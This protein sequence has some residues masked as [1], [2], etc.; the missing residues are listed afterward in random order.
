MPAA[1]QELP[2]SQNYASAKQTQDD[3]LTRYRMD[4]TK[5]AKGETLHIKEIFDQIP[6]QLNTQ[7]KCFTF[8]SLAKG[9]T[10]DGFI[11]DFF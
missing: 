11:R 9:G 3:I 8:S 5:Y 7:S 10:Y 1:V 2:D 6:S 4:L